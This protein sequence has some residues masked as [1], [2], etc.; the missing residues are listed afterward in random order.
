MY[1]L[2]FD[3]QLQRMMELKIDSEYLIK[4]TGESDLGSVRQLKILIDTK[5]QSLYDISYNLHNLKSLTLDK[6][7]IG[8]NIRDF[9]LDFNNLKYLSMNECQLCDLEGISCLSKLK[10][11]SI[12]D[13]NIFDV[14]P[15][16]QL[17]YVEV[18]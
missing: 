17:E 15:L 8:N 12:A 5:H 2:D 4:E 16:S 14:T 9:G 10:E 7:Y 6:S 11:L 1:E 3:E 13:N 18:S